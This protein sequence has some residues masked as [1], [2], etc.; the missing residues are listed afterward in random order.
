MFGSFFQ[1]VKM[2]GN[3]ALKKIEAQL[4]RYKYFHI[5][6]NTQLQMKQGLTG[7][8]IICKADFLY[9]CIAELH[10]WHVHSANNE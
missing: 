2:R 8:L 6:Y 1:Q 10:T 9:T 5:H 4:Y 3:A 7:L